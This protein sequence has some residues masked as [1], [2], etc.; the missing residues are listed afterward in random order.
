MAT[1]VIC[2]ECGHSNSPNRVTCK[3]CRAN[4]A[5][6][7]LRAEALAAAKP[8]DEV[9]EAAR[10]AALDAEVPRY[11]RQ[12]YRV[13]VRTATTAQ[14]VKPKQFSILM[15]LLLSLLFL[16]PGLLY[17]LFYLSQKDQT[18]YLQVDKGGT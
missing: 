15:F 4:L 7:V 14:L 10:T 1:R 6:T 2:P 16:L 13:T 17:L 11:I 12:G 8:G 5:E 3:Q 9:V 18:V